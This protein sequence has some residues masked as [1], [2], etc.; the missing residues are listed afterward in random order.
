MAP[1][2]PD[3]DPAPGYPDHLYVYTGAIDAY[4]WSITRPPQWPP[5]RVGRYR[6]SDPLTINYLV[7]KAVTAR[8]EEYLS[9]PQRQLF[10]KLGI[11]RMLLETDPYGN[12][13]AQ[14]L[15]AGDGPRL[16]A[17]WIA[18]S[19]RRC[20]EWGA[21]P[22]GRVRQLRPYASAGLVQADLWR[23]V[24]A[25][26]NRRLAAARGRIPHG[27]SGRTVRLHRTDPRPRGCPTRA[28][29]RRGGR[30]PSVTKCAKAA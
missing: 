10:D 16:G 23:L 26:Q 18:L 14:R 19:S 30:Q 3:Y 21:T 24:L 29:Q 27:R 1:Y 5:N 9:Y 15:R 20:L 7:K 6:N 8:G 25:E 11:R 12:F 13:P 2:D 4:R 28:L 22:A 17:S